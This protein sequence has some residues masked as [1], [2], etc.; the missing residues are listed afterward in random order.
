MVDTKEALRAE[1]SGVYRTY[2]LQVWNEAFNQ[3]RVEASSVLRKAE[4]V[5]YP[6]A[7]RASPSNSSEVNTLPEIADPEKR[8]P[9]EVPP[10]SSSLPKVAE[11][12]GV[13]GKGAEVTKGVAPNAT[14]PSVA[15]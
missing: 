9:N 3:A 8:S 12:P 13:N 1:V 2:Y 5:Y 4:S 6:S 14:K 15:P 11:Q 10:S 7:I